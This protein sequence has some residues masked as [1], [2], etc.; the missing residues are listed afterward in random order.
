M[1]RSFTT[2]AWLALL[3]PCALYGGALVAQYGSGLPP[4]EMCYWQ[5]WPHQSAI[6]LA[7][8]AIILFRWAPEPARWLVLAAALAIAVSGGIGAWH[9]GIEYGWWPGLTQCTAAPSGPVSLDDLFAAPVIRCD[10]PAWTL[11]PLSL[12]GFNAI[13]SLTGAALIVWRWRQETAA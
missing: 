4:C 6:V 2:A 10:A 7:T 12:A 1:L 3:I 13:L 8:L 5:R 11:G 9:A